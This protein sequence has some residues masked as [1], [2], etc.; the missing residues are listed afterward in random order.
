MK[1]LWNK[2]TKFLLTIFL[3]FSSAYFQL[4]PIKIFNLDINN[5]T[6]KIKILLT[7]FSN[8]INALILILMY[9]KDIKK[10]F[11]VFLE[12][13]N[14]MLD[15]GFKIWIIGLILMA[16]SNVVINLLS[17]N[18]IASNEESI[19]AM[20]T[21]SPYIMLL[22][23]SVLAPLIEE[24]TFRKAF[25]DIIDNKWLFVI[26]SGFVFGALHVVSN[27]RNLYDFLYL[28]PYCSL[29]MAL[30]YMYSKTKNIFV[31]ISMHSLHNFLITVMNIIAL[32]MIILC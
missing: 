12:N 7:I 13:K 16:G 4:I 32:G 31:P 11:K 14:E 5:L 24:L 27:I 18:K 19:R 20:I 1:H 6:Q 26:I 9:Y 3:F 10:D 30:S 25:K 15:E 17:P 23:T 2:Y 22:N 29:G 8:I 28:I 21:A